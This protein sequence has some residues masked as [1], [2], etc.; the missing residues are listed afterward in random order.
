V[1]QARRGWTPDAGA[2]HQARQVPALR[3]HNTSPGLPDAKPTPTER[4]SW[5]AEWA[6]FRDDVK[7]M[8]R[9]L[10]RSLSWWRKEVRDE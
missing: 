4:R 3:P 5:S 7:D 2:A 6:A 10:R 1:R 9:D 8:W